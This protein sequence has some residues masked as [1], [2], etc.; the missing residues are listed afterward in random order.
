MPRQGTMYT[1]MENPTAVPGRGAFALYGFH[2]G[3]VG[4]IFDIYTPGIQADSVY[5]SISPYR[6]LQGGGVYFEQ[7]MTSFPPVLAGSPGGTWLLMGAVGSVEGPG[8][9][10]GL[11]VPGGRITLDGPLNKWH[12]QARAAAFSPSGRRLALLTAHGSLWVAE[13]SNPPVRVAQIPVPYTTMLG[14]KP[15][16]PD[17]VAWSP[18]GHYLLA[19]FEPHLRLFRITGS[20]ATLLRQ[21]ELPTGAGI[22]T[23]IAGGTAV[24]PSTV[25]IRQSS[26]ELTAAGAGSAVLVPAPPGTPPR[27]TVV[28]ITTAGRES[29]AVAGGQAGAENSPWALIPRGDQDPSL[30][31]A[32]AA[33]TKKDWVVL[34]MAGWLPRGRYTVTADWP[35]GSMTRQIDF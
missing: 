32:V 8:Y 21:V 12:H 33:A 15:P 11:L 16:P 14:R 1:G 3:G 10:Y 30:F 31:S 35:G 24:L 34:P 7:Q 6:P 4:E 23:W 27:V 29:M 17:A 5:S 13:G 18:D 20:D 28:R 9:V 26:R 22:W 19:G 2:G 25:E